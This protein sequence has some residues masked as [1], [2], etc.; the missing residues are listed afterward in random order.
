MALASSW[1]YSSR[2]NSVLYPAVI[3][4]ERM[5]TGISSY[6]SKESLYAKS[7]TE[8]SA[9]S[10]RPLDP[11]LSLYE[12]KS[13]VL[14]EKPADAR[15]WMQKYLDRQSIHLK[16]DP[17]Y[18]N[19]RCWI[20]QGAQR[21]M[22]RRNIHA[23]VRFKRNGKI[24]TVSMHCGIIA[25]CMRNELTKD[26]IDG[27]LKQP[28]WHLSHLCGNWACCNPRH[29]TI[30][31]ARDNQRRKM[32]FNDKRGLLQHCTHTP[33]SQTWNWKADAGLSMSYQATS[34]SMI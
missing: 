26:M 2:S 4:H 16:K 14:V 27:L 25:L 6:Q 29:M 17:L 9:Q 31:P 11:K 30:E 20:H 8:P 10:I 28:S 32:C 13:I 12:R 23:T 24:Q 33:S 19:S 5:A 3:L 7:P 34:S 1:W 15:A 18:P 22:D 21:Y